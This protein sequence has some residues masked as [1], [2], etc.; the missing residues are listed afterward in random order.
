MTPMTE[1]QVLVSVAHHFPGVT[2][3]PR[4]VAPCP[5]HRKT[6][7]AMR[8]Q[9]ALRAPRATRPI[10]TAPLTPNERKVKAAFL[11]AYQALADAFRS[12][13]F[14]ASFDPLHN[15]PQLVQPLHRLG[16]SWSR[17]RCLQRHPGASGKRGENKGKR[18]LGHTLRRFFTKAGPS[19]AQSTSLY[20]E[21]LARQQ[22]ATVHTAVRLDRIHLR[23]LQGVNSYVFRDG[24][25]P[26]NRLR[27]VEMPSLARPR[28]T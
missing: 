6:R 27:V 15:G 12:D 21:L 2:L 22:A 3:V 23:Y 7:S 11:G 17:C 14:K 24:G 16:Q 5:R 9:K 1:S 10:S 13:E 25:F 19:A 4:G 26:S 20:D 28:S 8:A 18:Q